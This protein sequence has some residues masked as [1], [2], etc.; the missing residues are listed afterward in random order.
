MVLKPEHWARLK[1]LFYQAVECSPED[2]Q[3][4]L[5]E[6]CPTNDELRP[7]LDELLAADASWSATWPGLDLVPVFEESPP[8]IQGYD[9][10]RFLTQGGM[11]KVYL[12]RRQDHV[13]DGKTFAIKVLHSNRSR[14]RD[15]RRF[16]EERRLLA[17]LDHPNIV[18]LHDCGDLEDGRPYLVLDYIEGQRLDV[19][20]HSK[21]TTVKDRLKLF[22][23]ICTALHYAH[24][25][26]VVHRDLKPSNILVDGEGN[27]HLLDFG[28]AKR[29]G[30]SAGARNTTTGLVPMTLAYAS[31]E[32]IAS[33]EVTTA[34]DLYSLGLIL[35]E[36][37]TDRLPELARRDQAEGIRLPRPSEEVVESSQAVARQTTVPR[38]RRQLQGDL[39]EIVAKALRVTPAARYASAKEMADDIERHLSG[40]PILARRGSRRYLMGR[41]IWRYR[42]S[43]AALCALIFASVLVI[44]ALIQSQELAATNR[45]LRLLAGPQEDHLTGYEE[46]NRATRDILSSGLVEEDKSLLLQA[47]QRTYSTEEIF[48]QALDILRGWEADESD[49]DGRTS[50]RAQI[51]LGLGW[52][53]FHGGYFNEAEEVHST[54]LHLADSVYERES[55][56]LGPYLEA[57]AR[58]LGELERYS[59]GIADLKRSLRLQLQVG[60]W[61]NDA[62]EPLTYLGS[63]L[64][65]QGKPRESAKVLR[66]A[67]KLC[68]DAGDEPRQKAQILSSLA[69]SLVEIDPS[70]LSD[71]ET[72]AREALDLTL[73]V[74]G[75]PHKM[76]LNARYNL[77][78]VLGHSGHFKEAVEMS[79]ELVDETE[80]LLGPDHP[81]LGYI[82]TGLATGY[83]DLGQPNL[84]VE[85]AQRAVELREHI[86]TPGNWLIGFSQKRLAFCLADTG[87]K[88]EAITMLRSAIK[89]FENSRVEDSVHLDIALAKLDAW[90]AESA[91]SDG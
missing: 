12:G 34:S 69:V 30:V 80:T 43:L 82:L 91:R 6:H 25:R 53:L 77:A 42:L 67:L 74:Y 8:E 84:C 14:E 75:T 1:A 3:P 78:V 76:T 18:R 68:K 85:H 90:T 28:I 60:P 26:Q 65:L 2:L 66:T 40:Q 27:P 64:H 33:K 87:Q 58:V 44:Q 19:Y 31:P 21:R 56:E 23:T 11:G 48:V 50:E 9:N 22:Q 39:D 37:L 57:R 41:F 13:F 79:L 51:A 47:V 52:I 83:H 5:D 38:L 35:F 73:E 29:I 89:I 16:D 59:E 71:A 15:L 54:A 62:V 7:H 81:G 24:Q 46:L 45:L 49:R 63:L 17:E 55:P 4:F 72:F 10:L 32:Q 36:L 20:C 61:G 88:D 86:L 70:Y